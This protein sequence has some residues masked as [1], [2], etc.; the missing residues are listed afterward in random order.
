MFGFIFHGGVRVFKIVMLAVVAVLLPTAQAAALAQDGVKAEAKDGK[1]QSREKS[2][3]SG[4]VVV[5][6]NND[7]KAPPPPGINTIVNGN[8]FAAVNQKSEQFAKCAKNVD[9]QSLGPLIDGDMNSPAQ[10]YALD[11][12]IRNNLGCYP[13]LPFGTHPPEL[14]ECNAIGVFDVTVCRNLYDRGALMEAAIARYAPDATLN[15]AEVNDT[16]I[17]QRLNLREAGRNGKRIPIDRFLFQ[18][19]ICMTRMQPELVTRIVQAHGDAALQNAL[20][21]KVLDETRPCIGGAKK[22][23]M[24]PTQLRYYLVDAFYRWVVA[25]RDVGTLLQ[26]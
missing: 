18:V 3:Q 16:A 11:R 6:G 20:T 12:I 21:M 25:A 1:V 10:T 8:A 23:R 15:A 17:Q 7:R 2:S 19:G 13:D 5:E 14:G 24:E 9:A 22:V 26:S 4:E